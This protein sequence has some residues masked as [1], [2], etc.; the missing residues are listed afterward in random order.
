MEANRAGDTPRIPWSA[1]GVYSGVVV[2]YSI[3]QRLRR[4][5][6]GSGI[7]RIP[8]VAW[9]YEMI[10]GLTAPRGIVEIPVLSQYRM[11]VDSSSGGMHPHLLHEGVYEKKTTA[12]LQR[13]LKPGMVFVNVGANIGYFTVLAASLVAPGGK[14]FAIEPDPENVT[15]LRK[16]LALNGCVDAVTVGT[17][18]FGDHEGTV[19]LHKDAT[20]RGNHSL[21]AGNVVQEQTSILV[22]CTTID[23]FFRDRPGRID[24]MKI[25][26][27]GAE[28]LILEGAVE[29]I[30][31]HPEMNLIIEFWPFGL[32]N[33]GSDPEALLALLRRE[34]FTLE[35]IDIDL[36]VAALTPGEI[37]DR[38]NRK[39]A[40]GR[41]SLNLLA[42]RTSATH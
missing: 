34:G 23:R 29:T 24:V 21:A 2:L 15:F 7:G 6:A 20:N 35:A 11:L 13:T 38:A 12:L 32:R 30:R 1:S 4:S 17:C 5:A 14:V 33:V 18:C 19:T 31:S 27:Q 8:G 40:N 26:T 3:I 28:G 42:R 16:N 10:F 22:P 25:D 36:D 41:G 39:K 9:L 37:I